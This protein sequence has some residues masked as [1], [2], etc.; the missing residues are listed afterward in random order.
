MHNAYSF[1]VAVHANKVE[2][3]KAIETLF[4]VKVRGVRTK[5]LT[6]PPRRLGVRWSKP[7][8]TKVA[9]VTLAEGETIELI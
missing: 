2:I 4:E 6:K 8:T 5:R 3:R 9:V 1:E 7:K